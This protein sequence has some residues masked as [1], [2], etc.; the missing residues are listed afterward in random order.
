V[1]PSPTGYAIGPEECRINFQSLEQVFEVEDKLV[2]FSPYTELDVSFLRLKRQP[3][4]HPLTLHSKPVVMTQPP[5]RLYVIG[6]PG[7]GE[8]GFSLQDNYLIASNETHLY[9]RA[10]TEPGSSGSPIFEPE[11]W[12]VV[13]IHHASRNKVPG[14][15]EQAGTHESNEGISILAIQKETRKSCGTAS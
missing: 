3:N 11:D 14:L 10:L 13:G 4:T 6:Y 7:G 12:R 1:S 2:W 5:S 9:Y 8:L 15:S